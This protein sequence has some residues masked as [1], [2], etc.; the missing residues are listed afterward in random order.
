M[1]SKEAMAEE[2]RRLNEKIEALEMKQQLEYLMKKD[3]EREARFKALEDEINGLREQPAA[4]KMQKQPAVQPPKK[5]EAEAKAAT[6]RSNVT[7]IVVVDTPSA[8][9]TEP[10]L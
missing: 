9:R 8:R 10:S 1:T 5:T 4:K 3:V 6:K 2:I 7:K